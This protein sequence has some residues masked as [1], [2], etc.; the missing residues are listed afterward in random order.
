MYEDSL[1]NYRP[2][3]CGNDNKSGNAYFEYVEIWE[4]QITKYYNAYIPDL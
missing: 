4:D 1:T 3:Y 2:I